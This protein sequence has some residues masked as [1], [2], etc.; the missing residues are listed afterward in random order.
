M[1]VFPLF[2]QVQLV[3]QGAVPRAQP[4]EGA[5]ADAG[6]DRHGQVHSLR[7]HPHSYSVA[8]AVHC[9][10][11]AVGSGNLRGTGM[12]LTGKLQPLVRDV[13]RPVRPL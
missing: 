6:H 3:D 13:S 11:F 9:L 12:V 1:C 5:R 8:V 2:L 7:F 10:L 4:V